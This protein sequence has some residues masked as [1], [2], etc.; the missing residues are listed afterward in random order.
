MKR[1]WPTASPFLLV[2]LP[3]VA[4][5]HHGRQQVSEPERPCTRRVPHLSE[6]GAFVVFLV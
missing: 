2:L 4:Q 3:R 6:F 5:H 1:D